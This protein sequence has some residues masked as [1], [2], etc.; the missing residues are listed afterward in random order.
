MTLN[1]IQLLIGVITCFSLCFQANI[2]AQNKDYPNPVKNPFSS[3]MLEG[4]WLPENTHDIDFFSLPKIPSQQ[5]RK[6]VV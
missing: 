2:S 5:D 1:K 6:S 4:N 3:L